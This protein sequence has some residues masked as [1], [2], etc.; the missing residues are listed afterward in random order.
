MK[1]YYIFANSKIIKYQFVNFLDMR[2]YRINS[3]N[4][5]FTLM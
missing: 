4:Y 5:G 3:E 2:Y 1:T